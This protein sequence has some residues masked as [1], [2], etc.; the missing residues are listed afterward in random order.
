[1][2]ETIF[3]FDRGITFFI[4]GAHTPLWDAIMLFFSS[5]TVWIPLYLAMA[6][7]MFFPKWYGKP[8][9]KGWVAALIGIGAI[10][11]AFGLTDQICNLLK[12]F[13]MIIMK[14]NL[15]KHN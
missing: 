10:L 3:E 12:K 14:R 1:M 13:L 2:L 7:A 9:I 8:Q 11:V 5:K 15:K 6:A 4:N